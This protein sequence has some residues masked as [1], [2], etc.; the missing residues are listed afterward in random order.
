MK[1]YV[2]N[3]NIPVSGWYS[4]ATPYT[5]IDFDVN[6][7]FNID[8]SNLF[9]CKNQQNFAEKLKSYLKNEIL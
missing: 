5:Y 4:T 2:L 7:N 8:N 6:S 9:L 3:Y 1:G